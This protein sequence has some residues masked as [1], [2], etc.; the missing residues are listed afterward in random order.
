M[1]SVIQYNFVYSLILIGNVSK[2]GINAVVGLCFFRA[3]QH[4]V[5]CDT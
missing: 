2:N 5:A 1:F 4:P 3:D